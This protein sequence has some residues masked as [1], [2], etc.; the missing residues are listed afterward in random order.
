MNG[1]VVQTSEIREKVPGFDRRDRTV[2]G[3]CLEA[4]A[5][6]GRV[7]ADV[8]TGWRT[9]FVAGEKVAMGDLV[10]LVNGLWWKVV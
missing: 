7:L 1:D 10:E 8:G 4:G 2:R 3:K 5:P 6:G 9:A